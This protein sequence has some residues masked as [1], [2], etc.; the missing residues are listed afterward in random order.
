M[1]TSYPNS[2]DNFVN[3]TATD[4][5]DS[6]AVPHADQH[7]N[8]NDAIEAIQA[9]LGINP[10]GSYATVKD[11]II[12]VEQILSQR[13]TMFSQNSNNVSITGGSVVG[14]NTFDNIIING[15]TF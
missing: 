1:P 8:A 3:P 6:V 13:G 11:R 9:I 5:L 10:S 15:G 2:F 7:A 12:A 4:Y 14:L